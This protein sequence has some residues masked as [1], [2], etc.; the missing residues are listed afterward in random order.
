[1]YKQFRLI[2]FFLNRDL[3]RDLVDIKQELDEEVKPQEQSNEKK[4][5]H[6][7]KQHV[8]ASSGIIQKRKCLT[9]EQKLKIIDL[10]KYRTQEQ[11]SRQFGIS[12]SA[13][14]TILSRR[15]T[16]SDLASRKPLFMKRNQSRDPL[17]AVLE[18]IVKDWILMNTQYH[19]PVTKTK[20]Q[21]KALAVYEDLKKSVPPGTDV[22]DFTASTGWYSRFLKRED[23]RNLKIREEG[24][25]VG[26]VDAATRFTEEFA[27]IVSDGGYTPAQIFNVDETELVWKKTPDRTYLPGTMKDR[28]TLL[29]GGNADGSFKLKPVLIHKYKNP[30]ALKNYSPESLPVSYKT[31][32]KASMTSDLFISW[33]KN[34]FKPEVERFCEDN[35]IPFKILLTMDNAPYHPTG[36]C[37]L[38][39]EISVVFFPP[40]TTSLI[41]PMDQGVITN[42]KSYYLRESFH[43]ASSKVEC[44]KGRNKVKALE[45]FWKNFN[46][47]DVIELVKASW[48]QVTQNT[49][50]GVWGKILPSSNEV[51]SDIIEDLTQDI[52]QYAV[53]MDCDLTEDDIRKILNSDEATLAE[54]EILEAPEDNPKSESQEEAVKIENSSENALEKHIQTLLK[55]FVNLQRLDNDIE[56]GFRARQKLEEII[57]DLYP[58]KKK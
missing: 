13:V 28:V 6:V 42:F 21:M 36:I 35:H 52:L 23:L 19:I 4:E 43:L 2:V 16:L 9:L 48:G 11:L 24:D 37:G 25:S 5:N 45:R 49:L 50:A 18:K 14:S 51:H 32:R 29:L 3:P 58:I 54:K 17:I 57:Y 34:E 39:D 55:N 38:F 27:K 12:R 53:A 15:N 22:K 7:R 33:F 47:A 46:I 26:D 20:I 10:S 30:H 41:Q 44:A 56:R 8:K 1:M 31:Q 40:N